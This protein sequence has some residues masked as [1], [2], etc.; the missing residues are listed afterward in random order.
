MSNSYFFTALILKRPEV[1][2]TPEQAFSLLG[3]TFTNAVVK[4]VHTKT[5]SALATVTPGSTTL[6]YLVNPQIHYNLT[7]SLTTI[8]GNASN[9]KREFCLAKIDLESICLFPY[10]AAK[11]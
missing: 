3:I 2:G 1:T 10:I 11:K 4:L 7:G 9:K 6:Q 5:I 8:I